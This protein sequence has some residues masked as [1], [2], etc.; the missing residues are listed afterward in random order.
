MKVA[1]CC[2]VHNE[3][4]YLKEYIEHYKKIGF[5]K[6]FIYDH[7]DIDGE[8]PEDVLQD[9]IDE[10]FVEII[11]YR[12]KT[13]CQLMAYENCYN[14]FNKDFDWIA[15]FDADEFL[16]IE[17]F[18]NISDFLSQEKFR[19]FNWIY[20]NWVVYGDNNNIYYENKPINERFTKP[21][22]TFYGHLL[23]SERKSILR[24]G[25]N[26]LIWNIKYPNA[27]A[28]GP[29]FL[30]NINFPLCLQCCDVLG[31]NTRPWPQSELRAVECINE[32]HLKHY[33]TKSTEEYAY[34][35]LRGTAEWKNHKFNIQN[36]V[37][38]YF[39]INEYSEEKLNLINKIYNEK[40]NSN[41]INGAVTNSQLS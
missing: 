3:N 38:Y 9:Y 36:I 26:K 35:R 8:H 24:G 1:L 22:S 5:S 32:C 30:Y 17:N 28:D 25:M 23:S 13:E 29:N 41:N 11:N 40:S 18:T 39:S 20:V 10:N 2:I 19:Q 37:N 16:H 27:T 14:K 4:K 34:K 6:I 31:I 7:N 33:V 15:F 21:S 12:D